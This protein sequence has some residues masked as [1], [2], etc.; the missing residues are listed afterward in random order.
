MWGVPIKPELII[1]PWDIYTRLTC[2]GYR[3]GGVDYGRAME[4]GYLAISQLVGR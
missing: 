2:F 3:W 1:I 4:K